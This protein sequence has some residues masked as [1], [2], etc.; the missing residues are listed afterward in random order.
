MLF[1]HYILVLTR[2]YSL[3]MLDTSYK[4][5]HLRFDMNLCMT[6]PHSRSKFVRI[7]ATTKGQKIQL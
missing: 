1:V 5:N 7:T 3:S 4:K 2:K 6:Q